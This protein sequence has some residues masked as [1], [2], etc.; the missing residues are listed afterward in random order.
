VTQQRVALEQ[1]ENAFKQRQEEA[2]QRIEEERQQLEAFTAEEQ[3]KIKR[4]R[5][6]AE[7]STVRGA[8]QAGNEK[9]LREDLQAQVEALQAAAQAKDARARLQE[10]RLRSQLDELKKRNSELEGDLAFHEQQRLTRWKAEER[11]VNGVSSASSVAHGTQPFENANVLRET[12][13]DADDDADDDVDDDD[14][15]IDATQTV[16]KGIDTRLRD[17]M[18]RSRG[19]ADELVRRSWESDDGDGSY[20][21]RAASAITGL[22]GIGQQVAL[23]SIGP[24]G[25]GGDNT[26]P[27]LTNIN[28]T[29]TKPS[30][31]TSKPTEVADNAAADPDPRVRG[32]G[33][34]EHGNT[35]LPS[36]QPD[37]NKPGRA[38]A[39][40]GAPTP[41]VPSGP[42]SSSVAAGLL[43]GG[44]AA[45]AQ[46]AAD[47]EMEW[48]SLVDSMPTLIPIADMTPRPPPLIFE[49]HHPDGK[50]EQVI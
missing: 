18:E 3:R 23:T 46:D 41:A 14:A 34:R 13:A 29:S 7:R 36:Q 10:G 4:D 38:R 43:A 11:G 22:G 17:S 48:N 50:H 49:Q 25:G 5:R 45:H 20:T 42:S 1:R 35:P 33:R 27:P 44:V 47:V 37:N 28:G 2:L 19:L 39:A 30:K 21:S 8:A 12:A 24:H 16:L 15:M 26:P 32:R 6:N 31:Q 9:R 40:P